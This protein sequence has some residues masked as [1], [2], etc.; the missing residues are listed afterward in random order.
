MTP[1]S[2]RTRRGTRWLV[3]DMGEQGERPAAQYEG[4]RGTRRRLDLMM[5]WIVR[6]EFARDASGKVLGY[7][8]PRPYTRPETRARRA[9]ERE[10]I[11]ARERA[12]IQ[13]RER[14]FSRGA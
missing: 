9:A 6:G 12:R 1:A 7:V 3:V 10:A 13:A 4:R 5:R 8:P 2:P 11:Q 14:A